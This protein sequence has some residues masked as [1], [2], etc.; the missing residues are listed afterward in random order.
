MAWTRS[1]WNW[2]RTALKSSRTDM[3]QLFSDNVK[4]LEAFALLHV[5]Q[6]GINVRGE[7]GDVAVHD[8]LMT[9]LLSWMLRLST[10][11]RTSAPL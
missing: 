8:A 7:A 5:G 9:C 3:R 11:I 4:L 2:M 6:R 1:P 10:S